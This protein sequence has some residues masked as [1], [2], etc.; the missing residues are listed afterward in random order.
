MGGGAGACSWCLA[1]PLRAPERGAASVSLL[2]MHPGKCEQQ[3]TGGQPVSGCHA[4]LYSM[5]TTA[6]LLCS[7]DQP[8]VVWPKGWE[9]EKVKLDATQ[10]TDAHGCLWLGFLSARPTCMHPW[11]GSREGSPLHLLGT[12]WLGLSS[13]GSAL[14]TPNHMFGAPGLHPCPPSYPRSIPALHPRLPCRA[15]P[16][17]F[18]GW[19]RLLRN[20]PQG[21]HV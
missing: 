10:V 21:L 11:R 19:Q 1:A 9:V 18:P 13:Q 12:G 17:S 20:G 14:T 15:D 2:C 4:L 16:G 6:L 3:L 8:Q 7:L 5:L